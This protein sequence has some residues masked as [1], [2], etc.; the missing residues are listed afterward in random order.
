MICNAFKRAEK[1][2][3]AAFVKH[4][5]QK[6]LRDDDSTQRELDW[7]IMSLLLSTLNLIDDEEL[8]SSEACA[9]LW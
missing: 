3:E 2:D 7:Q 4:A 9:S 1:I 8:I 6:L 5:N